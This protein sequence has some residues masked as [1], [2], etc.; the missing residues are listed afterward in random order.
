M[1]RAFRAGGDVRQGDTSHECDG[2]AI[3][4]APQYSVIERAK[5]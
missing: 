2:R 5:L 1:V 3:Y 4:H